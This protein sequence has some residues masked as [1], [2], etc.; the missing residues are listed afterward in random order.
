MALDISNIFDRF[1]RKEKQNSKAKKMVFHLLEIND[2]MNKLLCVKEYTSKREFRNKL[3][4]SADVIEFFK[5]LS[6]IEL[7][8][9]FCNQNKIGEKF[10][11][12]T[13]KRFENFEK[14]VDLKNESYINW[15]MLEEKDYLDSILKKC[16]P[17]IMLDEDQRRVVL[18][19]EDYCMVVAGAGAGK[20][21]TVAAKVKYLV[22]KNR[23]SPSEICVISFT[24]KA[25][26]E[27][28]QRI[29]KDLGM[30]ECMI[31][32]FHSVGNM[33]LNKNRQER[34]SIVDS[35]KLYFVISDYLKN[36]VLKKESMVKNL[37]LFFSTYFEVPYEGFDLQKF[38]E[39]IAKSNFTTLKS[40][41]NDFSQILTDIRTGKKVTIQSEK[42]RSKQEV[43][44]ANFLYLNS[45]SYQYEPIYNYNI[46]YARKP[47][48]PDFIIEQGDKKAY[49]EHFGITEDGKN[50]FFSENAL[51]DYKKAIEDK[52]ELHKKHGTCLIYTFSSY[53]DGRSIQSHLKEELEKQ[54]FTLHPRSEKEVVE[55]VILAEES[56]YIRKLTE[57]ITRFITNFKTN[58][59]EMH[60]FDEMKRAT[61]NVRTKLFLEIC[62]D[63]YIE[64]EK[65][66]KDHSSIDFQD[67]INES[68]K[69]LTQIKE[70]D[71]KLSYKYI[72]V[73]EYQDI[74]R[75]RFD[76]VKAL[77]D[78]TDAKIIAVGDDWQSIYA[79]SGSDLSLFTKFEETMGYAKEMQILR[80]YRNSQE[81]IDIA[82]HFI[83]KNRTQRR[84]KLISNKH[85]KD[86]V[87]IYTYDGTY[88]KR[89]AD[90]RSGA[91]Y[92]VAHTVETALEK[93]LSFSEKEG[94][95]EQSTILLVGRYGY[96]GYNLEKS[97][98]FEY[99]KMSGRVKSLK[100]PN[101]KIEFLTA[102][103]SK[104]LGYDNVIMINAK[105]ETYGFPSKVENDP[106]LSFVVK[107]DKAIEYAEERRLFYVAMT[108]TK[109]RVYFIAPEEN[110]SEF[111]VEIK[112]DHK[113]IVLNGTWNED[114]GSVATFR[115]HCP[116]CSYPLQYKYKNSYGLALYICTNEPEICGFMTN[117]YGA[118]KLSIMKCNHCQ[119]GY[120]IVK[121]AR[122]DFILGCTNY[123]KDG[124]GCDNT[125]NR[126]YYN[127][128]MGIE[129]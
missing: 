72:I 44:I 68:A 93:I 126:K 82:G 16:D 111:L 39:S 100:F 97:G 104:G 85:I 4:E 10:V 24:N 14:L 46:V 13:L 49:I 79:F 83:Q 52:I 64:Y 88:K 63:C 91:N 89:S 96:D 3:S 117:Q 81:V 2:F 115:K 106:V 48:T 59:F 107:E 120:L 26:D 113:N 98:L 119:D 70:A 23:I 9:Q 122:D 92:A 77:S 19:E 86:P 37:L 12:E 114:S 95:S 128:L 42:L 36:S 45:I 118:G 76:L 43:E 33:I 47:Y 90:S 80:T 54:G 55:K 110:P 38:F 40:D 41:L 7:L 58:G 56:K 116:I 84:K 129:D 20:T 53:K 31:S 103:S 17:N 69:I 62:L 73:D 102:H 123:K 87:I 67:M 75:Q 109:N 11:Y 1:E 105:N 124:T 6:E 8:S 71:E 94:G 99:S 78:V 32:T 57:L 60:T 66:L 125:M 30:K 51:R 34:F 15:K 25:V 121:F 127:K 21:S 18:T 27:L 101:L 22:E 28:K 29:H 5:N 35:G 50:H 108:R 61:K 74:S 112:R 65:Y